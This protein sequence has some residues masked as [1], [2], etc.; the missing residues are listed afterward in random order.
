MTR[1]FDHETGFIQPCPDCELLEAYR[2]QWKKTSVRL[3]DQ[4]YNLEKDRDHWKSLFLQMYSQS[5]GVTDEMMWAY[6][7]EMGKA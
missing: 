7:N 5:A 3:I 6:R 4:N 2:D 1:D